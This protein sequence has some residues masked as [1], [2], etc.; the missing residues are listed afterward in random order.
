MRCCLACIH[1]SVPSDMTLL[2]L[3][4]AYKPWYTEKGQ[5][6]SLRRSCTWKLG[7]DGLSPAPAALSH[8][9]TRKDPCPTWELTLPTAYLILSNSTFS[10]GKSE[11]SLPFTIS[12][13]EWIRWGG[14][15]VRPGLR[16]QLSCLPTMTLSKQLLFVPPLSPLQLGGTPPVLRA[17]S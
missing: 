6:G 11:G 16:S 15:E 4:S 8:P 9:K 1:Q 14:K 7:G 10:H 5:C 17:T 12:E 2:A 3:C 13:V